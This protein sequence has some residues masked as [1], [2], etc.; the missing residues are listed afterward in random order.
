MNK[1]TLSGKYELKREIGRGGMG[2]IYEALHGT[3]NRTVAIKVLHAQYTG[4]PA[5]LKRFQR[6]ARAMAR[7]DHPNII[8]VFDVGEDDG[9]HYIVMEYFF[10]KDLK[11]IV[12]ERGII[13]QQETLAIAL[14]ITRA[15]SYA[16]A[17]GII[18]RD[19]KPGNI[20]VNKAGLV[21]IA[22]FGIAAAT[23][24]ASVTLTGHVLGTPKYMSVEQARGENLDSRSDLYSLGMVVYEML[25]GRTSFSGISEMAIL[26]KLVYE[27]NEYD[28]TF[29]AHI[30]PSIQNL[31]ST[32]LKKDK[33]ERVSDTTTLLNLLNKASSELKTKIS[34]SETIEE[35]LVSEL[36]LSGP[37]K[38]TETKPAEDAEDSLETVM[39]NKT[40]PEISH[41]PPPSS[42]VYR[43]TSEQRPSEGPE[44]LKA[45]QSK[46]PLTEKPPPSFNWTRVIL[47]I[48]GLALLF[49]GFGYY[50]SVMDGAF[51]APPA[52]SSLDQIKRIQKSIRAM[53]TK[54]T[55]SHKE[56]DVN[57][58]PRWA[59]DLYGEAF[60]LENRGEKQLDKA[61]EF[62]KTEQ[63]SEAKTR[64]QNTLRLFSASHEGF[65]NA[66]DL[67]QKSI[68]QSEKLKAEKEKQ[69]KMRARTEGLKRKR[70]KAEAERRKQEALARAEQEKLKQVKI[71]AEAQR[72]KEEETQARLEAEE[73][74]EAKRQ[75]LAQ[76]KA[77]AKEEARFS[78][79]MDTKY[80]GNHLAELKAAYEKK[81]LA[82]LKTLTQLSENRAQFLKQIFDHYK[83]IRVA[84]TDLAVFGNEAKA[85]ISIK[86]LTALD[87]NRVFPS[88]NWKDAQL[89]FKKA[90]GQWGKG[91]W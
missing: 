32:L 23:D 43:E 33:D 88:S 45:K 57:N 65:V 68:I 38:R 71:K 27:K 70:L 51:Q 87:G 72:K 3:L 54:L 77:K 11:E 35:I 73:Q 69:L 44:Q 74:A 31:V 60:D 14:Q 67:A 90:E 22:D 30:L 48:A 9:L 63:F 41:L 39:F 5:F 1:K 8:R 61:D 7:L 66:K 34:E 85:I 50:L 36:P 17:H 52:P 4:D 56:A 19:I 58:A 59:K 16:H 25:T 6:E 82:H 79:A 20:M 46:I 76:E 86:E 10:G 64:L 28:L 78:A 75:Q 37:A 84:I 40:P 47:V 62:I 80:L 21:K 89:S 12:L 29:Q 55:Q 24:E 13:P 83:R 2:V 81:D 49:T 18:H 91:R 26:G 15:L 42:D 53:Q